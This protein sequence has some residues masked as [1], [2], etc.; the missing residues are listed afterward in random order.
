MSNTNKNK[1]EKIFIQIASYRDPQLLPTLRDMFAS[2][3]HPEN[4]NVGI[5]WQ[6]CVDDEWDNLD[7][8]KDDKRVKIIEIDYKKAKGVCWARNAVQ[9]LYD[10]EDYTLQL[11]S[12]HRFVKDW[13]TKL[14]DM[15]KGL[16]KDGYKKPLITAYIPSFDPDNDPGSRVNLPWKMNF[17]R[18]I[19][20]GAVFFLPATFDSY[21]DSSKPL[22]AR[23][24]SAHFAF[25]LGSF[26][27][28]VRHD[29]NMYFHGEEISIAA[30]AFTHGYDLFHPNQVICWHEYTRKGRTKHWDDHYNW[31]VTNDRSHLRNRKLFGMDGEKQ[32]EDFSEYGFG[33][34]RTL[35]EYEKYAGLCFKKRA[36]SPQTKDKVAPNINNDVS[37]EEFYGCLLSIFR[38]CIDISFEQVPLQDYDFWCVAFKD[39]KGN[40]IYRQD[41]NKDEIHRM[42]TDPDGYCKVWREFQTEIKPNSWI[43][44]AHSESQGWAPPITGLL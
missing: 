4:I 7:E 12:H 34:E 21:D 1:P 39:E 11:D 6:R 40:D 43:V 35:L 24:Y 41:A 27:T 38:H 23:F 22:P 44:W 14:K 28:E 37:D 17:D 9:S 10:N 18:F 13:D 3:D 32:D 20:E 29:P 16:Q 5:A 42:K 25:S 15:L 36:I 30:R 33:K 26:A 19:P 8:Y 2:A 31:H